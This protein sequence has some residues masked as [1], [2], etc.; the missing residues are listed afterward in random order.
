MSLEPPQLAARSHVPDPHRC[1][2]VR[3]VTP[4][5][6]SQESAV[7]RE[8]QVASPLLVSF[9]SSDLL[10]FQASARSCIFRSPACSTTRASCRGVRRRTRQGWDMTFATNHLG[11]FALTEAL[12]PH[13]PDSANVVFVASA[14]ESLLRRG[15]PSDA[16]LRA[17]AAIRSSRI[18]LSPRPRQLLARVPPSS[19]LDART[20]GH[21]N[22]R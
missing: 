6:R 13:L 7:G 3:V 22:H 1:V 9:K 20:M 18:A 8:G 2:A 5:A 4:A 15:R 12:V 11:P 10:A 19:D 16:R 21:S 14:V 17:G